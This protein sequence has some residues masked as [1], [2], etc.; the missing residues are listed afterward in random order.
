MS[1]FLDESA[2]MVELQQTIKW[3][4][5]QVLCHVSSDRCLSSKYI[6][7]TTFYCSQESPWK[8]I[9][10]FK[11]SNSEHHKSAKAVYHTTKMTSEEPTSTLPYKLNHQNQ[12]QYHRNIMLLE[13]IIDAVILCGKQNIPL[14]GHRDDSTSDSSNKGNF[15][16]ILQ[17]LAKHDEHLCSHL[18]T[19]KKNA[20]YT[21]KT[22]QNEVIQI[23]GN[24]ITGKILKGLQGRGFYSIIADEVTDKYANKEVLVLCLRFLDSREHPAIIRE[25]FIDFANIER[26][27]GEAVAD[28]LTEILRLLAIP[29][30]NMRGQAYD[31]ASAMASEKRG[32]QG[33]IKSL[34]QLALFTH[35]RSHVLNLSIASACKLPLVRN[36]IDVLNS[37]FIFFDSSPKR[38]RFLETS[39]ENNESVDFSRKK[40]VGLCKTRWVERHVCFDVFY[41]M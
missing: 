11:A 29:I 6:C 7:Y 33:R 27:T 14:R 17:L 31:G 8:I 3:R 22:I 41:S 13:K 12:A 23:I 25:E 30:E 4:S 32:C 2:Y 34:N 16:A 26:T 9:C 37:V 35:C 10:P 5:V 39:I 21:S 1:I 40:L 38:Q 28:K 19:A 18:Q 36:M 24:H 15:L 20:L